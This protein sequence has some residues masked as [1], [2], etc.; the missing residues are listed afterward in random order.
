[1]WKP[2]IDESEV[3]FLR[4][5][6]IKT[7]DEPTRICAVIKF[8]T[9]SLDSGRPPIE[10]RQMTKE[11]HDPRFR[12]VRDE[13]GLPPTPERLWQRIEP[14]L[15]AKEQWFRGTRPRVGDRSA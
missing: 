14:T 11:S 15:R 13:S 9:K 12:D 3:R 2:D 4:Q 6:G 10:G 8:P 5:A 1:M 7:S